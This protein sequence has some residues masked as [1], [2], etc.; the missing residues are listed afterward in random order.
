M[1]MFSAVQ[2]MSWVPDVRCHHCAFP[3]FVTG[4]GRHQHRQ[5]PSAGRL[6]CILGACHLQRPEQHGAQC[7]EQPTGMQSIAG[8]RDWV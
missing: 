4:C 7:N 3:L 5:V 8:R 2:Y 1:H 6:L